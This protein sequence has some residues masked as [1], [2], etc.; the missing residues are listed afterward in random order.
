MAS[1]L[2]LISLFKRSRSASETQT[3]L[4]KK[5]LQSILLFLAVSFESIASDHYRYVGGDW[6]DSDRWSGGGGIPN[7]YNA[8]VYLRNKETTPFKLDLKNGTYTIHSLRVGNP[9]RSEGGSWTLFEGTLAFD[10][11]GLIWH[12]KPLIEYNGN[13]TLTFA[14]ALD[15]KANLTLNVSDKSGIVRLLGTVNNHQYEYLEK[16]GPGTLLIKAPFH[17]SLHLGYYNEK[18]NEGLEGGITGIAP[19]S[20]GDFNLWVEENSKLFALNGD[21]NL[22]GELHFQSNRDRNR[23]INLNIIDNPRD[24]TYHSI[25]FS[26][27]I[28]PQSKNNPAFINQ[29]S[30]GDLIFEGDNLFNGI[31]STFREYGR[32][33]LNGNTKANIQMNGGEI[34]GKGRTQGDLSITNEAIIS[35]GYKDE[36]GTLSFGNVYLDP[37]TILNFRFGSS[38]NDQVQVNGNLTL[39]GYLAVNPSYGFTAGT[40]TLFNY[41]GWQ[42]L[43][44]IYRWFLGDYTQWNPQRVPGVPNSTS[45]AA[46]NLGNVGPN[47]LNLDL[48][49]HNY[50]IG[51]LNV[52][53]DAWIL[54]NGTLTLDAG[55]STTEAQIRYN[56]PQTLDFETVLD[57]QADTTLNVSHEGGTVRFLRKVI[58]AG[59]LTKTGPGTLLIEAPFYNTLRLAGGTTGIAFGLDGELYIDENS[60]L[61][62]LNSN[63]N[64]PTQLTLGGNLDVIDNPNDL[65]PRRITLRGGLTGY[66]VINQ[67]SHGDLIF[68]GT[69]DPS[70]RYVDINTRAGYGRVILNGDMAANIHMYGGEIA[71]IGGT[72]GTLTAMNGAGAIVSPGYN[73]MIGTLSFGRAYLDPSTIL[74]FRANSI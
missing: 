21:I 17:V 6:D 38:N 4:A 26:G 10:R 20:L 71:G 57:L 39:A 73:Q 3:T 51:K 47:S 5:T 18:T 41:G 36:M 49:G 60:K 63:L 43:L 1:A 9:D 25:T 40:Y 31:I 67:Y 54:S 29:F 58:G 50:I 28:D 59:A 35:P 16:V 74:N 12:T 45:H 69:A 37:S 52:S 53:G 34:A 55:S 8:N 48:T 23:E 19:N 62:A 65:T 46:I 33:V 44:P 27:R 32:V 68:V 15:L 13:Q 30:H 72:Q 24:T 61:F 64:I 70:G 2:E 22:S 11:D 7:S 56:G 42:P 14:T 66:G